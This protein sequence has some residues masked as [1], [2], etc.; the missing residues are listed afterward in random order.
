M[1][2]SA[3]G[4]FTNNMAESQ[5]RPEVSLG[6]ADRIAID[7]AGADLGSPAP[8]DGVIKSDHHWGA[9]RHQG[10]Y[11]QDQQLTRHG[12][13]RPLCPAEDTMEGAEIGMAFAPKDTQRR[14]D[15]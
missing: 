15:G 8:F 1:T 13:R 14:C 11:Q 12:P 7:A 9:R 3:H 5:R 6:R 2:R 10:F 4:T